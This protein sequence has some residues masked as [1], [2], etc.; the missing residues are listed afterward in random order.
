[1]GKN[2]KKRNLKGKGSNRKYQTI[3]DVDERPSSGKGN[4][5]NRSSNRQKNKS[6]YDSYDDYNKLKKTLEA[7]GLEIIDMDPDGNCLFR[8]L[9][10]QLFG[11]Y[12]KSHYIVRSSVCDFM[13]Q[14]EDDFRLFLVFEDENDDGQDEEDAR[15]FEHYIG[16]MRRDGEWGGNLEVVAAARLFR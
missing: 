3:D 5:N 12:G 11:D 7:D 10:D 1:M 6:N 13:E 16:N 8:S 9:S 14:N 2:P 15:D 4:K